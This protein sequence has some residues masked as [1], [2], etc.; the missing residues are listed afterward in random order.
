MRF[1]NRRE[2]SYSIRKCAETL[3]EARMGFSDYGRLKS[4][5]ETKEKE[6][7]I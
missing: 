1:R 3:K 4:V 2:T 5:A 7:D 6:S